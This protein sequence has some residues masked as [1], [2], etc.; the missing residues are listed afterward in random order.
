[1]KLLSPA[2]LQLQLYPSP[3]GRIPI[4]VATRREDFVSLVRALAM[5]NEPVA[6][7]GSMGSVTVAGYN[8]W[9]RIRRLRE[10][11]ESE[12]PTGDWSIEFERIIPRKELYQDRFIILSDGP[13]SGVSAKDMG[14]MD[15]EWRRLS[16]HPPAP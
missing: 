11:W 3:A 1:M 12:H 2:K 4:I 5:K 8:D 9:S 10:K 16:C 7:P 6:I 14:V 15:K 13:Y